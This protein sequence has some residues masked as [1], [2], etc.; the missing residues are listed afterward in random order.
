VHAPGPAVIGTPVAPGSPA[1]TPPA[2]ATI[3]AVRRQRVGRAP[4]WLGTKITAPIGRR[5]RAT[6]RGAVR[7]QGV[8]KAIT[9]TRTTA[10]VEAGRT[11]TLRIRPKGSTAAAAAV[12]KRVR[13]AIRRGRDVTARITV[14]ITD[15][16]GTVQVARR[17]VKLV[18]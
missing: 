7:I 15:D 9:L 16:A 1:A 11:T 5:V 8:A 6:T 13:A 14:E 12:L 17:T 4:L 18:G 3:A 10:S 2:R